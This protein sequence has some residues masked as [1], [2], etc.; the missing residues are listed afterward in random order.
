M[1]LQAMDKKGLSMVIGYVLL[2][3]ISIVMSIIVYSYLKTYVPANPVECSEGTSLFI[4]EIAYACTPGAETLNITVKNNGKF[5]INGYFIRVSNVSNPDALAIIDIS[6]K[7]LIGGEISVNSIA[8]NNLIEN[9]L[10]P[11]EPT[12]VRMTSFNVAGYGRLY[13]V[14]IIPIRLQKEGNKKRVLSCDDARV[15]EMLTCR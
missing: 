10:T 14:E 6:S 3:A 5:S 15:E 4:K 12:N 11:S 2:I 8:F 9:Y 1:L 13:K 7:V